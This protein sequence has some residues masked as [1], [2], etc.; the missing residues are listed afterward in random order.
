[1]V[2]LIIVLLCLA[3]LYFWLVGHWFARILMTP[4]LWVVAGLG[5]GLF[6]FG[7]GILPDSPSTSRGIGALVWLVAIPVAWVVGAIPQE[8]ARARGPTSSLIVREI[9]F[10]R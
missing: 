4:V 9:S 10:G 6:V 5:L 7:S 3:L 1:M 2:A 8:R